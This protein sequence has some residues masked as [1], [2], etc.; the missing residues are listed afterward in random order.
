MVPC[1]ASAPSAVGRNQ[2]ALLTILQRAGGQMGK[3][4]LR[5]AWSDAGH[6]RRRYTEALHGLL[7]AGVIF[8]GMQRF[9]TVDP[10]ASE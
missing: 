2:R 9:A 3:A 6:D 5:Q 10:R 4:E 8:D 1:A 7:E